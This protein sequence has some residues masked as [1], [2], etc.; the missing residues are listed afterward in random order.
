[1]SIVTSDPTAGSLVRVDVTR[2]DATPAFAMEPNARRR[3]RSP[4][5]PVPVPAH[6]E[7]HTLTVTFHPGTTAVKDAVLEPAG[8]PM[9][10]I[11]QTARRGRGGGKLAEAD[12]ELKVRINA[13]H[14]R[15]RAL[16]ALANTFSMDWSASLSQIRVGLYGGAGGAVAAVDV[17]LEWPLNGA[18]CRVV[19]LAGLA[20]A[21]VAAAAQRVEPSGYATVTEALRATPRMLSRRPA[22]PRDDDSLVLMIKRRRDSK[23]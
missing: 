3:R 16:G 4:H 22:T 9:D 8:V 17:P 11:V 19:G 18:K 21:V 12:G 7:T 23:E 5:P 13:T 14:A 1:M 20:P 6:D 15:V 2:V 10:D